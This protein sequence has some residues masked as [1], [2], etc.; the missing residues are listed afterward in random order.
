M[1]QTLRTSLCSGA[2]FLCFAA[3]ADNVFNFAGFTFDQRNTPDQAA[4]LGNNLLLDGAQFSPGFASTVTG[5]IDNFPQGGAGFDTALSLAQLTGLD[6]GMK[7]V[8][9]PNGNNGTTTRHGIEVLWSGHRALPNLAGDD[10]VIYESASSISE[11]E[12]LMVRMRT[13]PI[14]LAE[15]EHWT[16]WQYYPP[17]SFQLTT[18]SQGLF[19]YGLDFSDFGVT[20]DAVIDKIQMANLIQADGV[21][22]PGTPIGGGTFVGIG[23]VVF[24]GSSNVLPDAGPFDSDRTFDTG[25]IDPDPA[26]VA[27]LH[28]LVALPPLFTAIKRQGSILSL[29][30][31]T[32]AGRWRIE[33][34]DSFVF[35]SWQAMEH[36]TN[37]LGGVMPFADSGQNG[38]PVPMSVS[39]RFYRAV[40]E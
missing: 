3:E 29:M 14:S 17:D 37:T 8:N 10:I 1:K 36:F 6:S 18:G 11:P 27:A 33:S 32:S 12:G 34:S 40:S 25:Q 28:D 35:P 26:Y 24:D 38:R 30:L 4:R 2:L 20:A 31:A 21:V 23:K 39:N 22:G 13:A 15:A 9:L 16:S 19:A 7:A 5:T